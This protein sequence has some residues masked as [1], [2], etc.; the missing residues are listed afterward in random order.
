LLVSLGFGM[1][2]EGISGVLGLDPDHA[3]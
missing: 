3:D 2:G 1:I